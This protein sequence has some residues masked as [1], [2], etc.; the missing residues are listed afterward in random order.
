MDM[1]AELNEK[2]KDICD[3]INQ[4]VD[5]DKIYLFGS[6]AY[7]APQEDSDFDLYVVIPDDGPRPIDVMK[8]I[9]RALYQKKEMPLDIL[10]GRAGDFESRRAVSSIE[11]RVYREGVLIYEQGA[12]EQ[13]MT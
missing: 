11:R 9:R 2:L 4:M 1:N 13:R 3:T 8:Q 12:E 7:G 10:V 5:V 6:Y